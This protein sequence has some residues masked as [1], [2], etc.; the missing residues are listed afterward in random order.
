MMTET[1]FTE[2]LS[3]FKFI[4]SNYLI[5]LISITTFDDEI[6]EELF[7]QYATK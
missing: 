5:L 6:D 1:Y 2:Q 3:N 4:Y 7:G